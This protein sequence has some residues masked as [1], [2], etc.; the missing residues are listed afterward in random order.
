MNSI[1]RHNYETF[2]LLYTDNELSAAEKKAVDEFV[3][4]N[5]DLQEEL[6][7]LQQSILK[8]D[9]IV[10]DDKRSLLKNEFIP[11]PV[12]EIL[13][14]HLDNELTAAGKEETDGLIKADADIKKEWDILQQTKLLPVSAIVFKDKRSLYRKEAGKEVAFP[15]W[16]VAVAAC[17]IGFGIWGGLVYF[18]NGTKPVNSGIVINAHSKPANETVKPG[19][20]HTATA[21]VVP[22]AVKEKEIEITSVNAKKVSTAPGVLSPE[23]GVRRLTV[24]DNQ[25]PVVIEKNNNLPKAYFDNINRINRN[26]IIPA[27]VIHEKQ[28]TGNNEIAKTTDR[29]DAPNVYA[30]TTSFTDNSEENNDRVLFMNEEKI[31]KT[32]IG[33]FF[34]KVKRVLERSA[35]IKPGDSNIKVANLEFAIQ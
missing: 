19:T 6:V 27:D 12:Q 20:Q 28:N 22:S 1:N 2:F 11:T 34:R 13:L 5:P 23:K 35:N 25:P 10:F 33:G 32:K 3:D 4:A 16:R 29:Q 21:A 14:L 15:W 31:K 18:N 30:T 26:E 7:M 17:F 24:R 8:P 9:H